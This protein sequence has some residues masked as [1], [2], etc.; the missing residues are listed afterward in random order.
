MAYCYIKMKGE[1][2]PDRISEI[3]NIFE[4]NRGYAQL[5]R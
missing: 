4:V 2:T 1:A 3:E 5:N